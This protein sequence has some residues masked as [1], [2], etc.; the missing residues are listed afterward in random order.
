MP[1]Y[2]RTTGEKTPTIPSLS[3][4]SPQ[5][6]K[7]NTNKP[8]PNPD[9]L[10]RLKGREY[11]FLV[12]DSL[13]MNPHWENVLEVFEALLYIVK[14]ADPNGLDLHFTVSEDNCLNCKETTALIRMVRNRMRRSTI[15]M[16]IRLIALLQAY[17]KK[18]SKKKALFSATVRPM[19]L[20]ILTDGVWEAETNVEDPIRSLV[21]TLNEKRM[22]RLQVGIQF[23]YFGDNQKALERL[24]HLDSRL[25]LD[26]YVWSRC[27][28]RSC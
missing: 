26:P 14:T 10:N 22:G 11:V 3:L 28:C 5:K 25:G 1:R 18:L 16:N 27:I 2:L 12:D 21:Q 8:I 6:D 17:Q 15:D 19:N 24:E 9:L 23:I 20:Y 4:R 7:K 13:S